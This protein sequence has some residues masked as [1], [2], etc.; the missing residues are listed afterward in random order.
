MSI[1]KMIE[2]H[3][4]AF[5]Y[6]VFG[7]FTVLVSWASYALFVWMGIELNISNIASWI[8]AVFFAFVVNKWFVFESRSTEPTVVAK[9]LS[10]FFGA[11]IFTGILAF[12]L[13]PVLL[14][15]GMDGGLFGV[16]GFPARIVTSLVEIALNW[17]FSKYL[18]FVKKKPDGD[19]VGGIEDNDPN[20]NEIAE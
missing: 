11:R 6:V 4:E 18:I 17:V 7:A 14:F 2:D 3:R 13:F 5:L 12:V 19:I 9:E 8:C 15:I 16:D 10:S 1:K 20:E